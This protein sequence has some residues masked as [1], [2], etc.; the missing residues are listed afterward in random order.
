MI[1]PDG[2]DII[3][4]Y[5]FADAN[6][7]WLALGVQILETTDG[8]TTWQP[9]FAVNSPVQDI[10]F[11]SIQ[12]GWIEMQGGYLVTRDGGATWQRAASKPED[13]RLPPPIV[14]GPVDEDAYTFCPPPR[15]GAEQNAVGRTLFRGRQ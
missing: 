15:V 14:P 8:G 2:T 7:G 12:V 13:N 1:D 6:H 4:A 11:V 5:S 3:R 9:R 10:H